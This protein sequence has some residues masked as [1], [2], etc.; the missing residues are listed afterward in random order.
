MLDIGGNTGK[1]SLKCVKHDPDVHMTIVDLPG[2]CA[3]AVKDRR[4]RKTERISTHEQNVLE[5]KYTLPKGVD[6]VWMSQFLDCFSPEQIVHILSHGK[7]ALA[8]DG[9]LYIQETFWDQQDNATATY[10]LH[11]TSLY[12]TALANGNSKMYD[13]N[14]MEQY[15]EEAGLVVENVVNKVGYFH[16]IMVCKL[17]G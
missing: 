9:R 16:S 4:S 5:A 12:F 1:W 15:V 2:Q 11:G 10:C 8:P 3:M 6:A 13:S 14:R 17:P 7:E